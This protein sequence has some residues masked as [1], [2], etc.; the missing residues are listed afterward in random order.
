MTD[1]EVEAIDS[2]DSQIECIEKE[3]TSH[4]A[5]NTTHIHDKCIVNKEPHFVVTSHIE[6]CVGSVDETGIHT[7][8]KEGSRCPVL[9]FSWITLPVV[10]TTRGY[11][12]IILVTKMKSTSFVIRITLVID[13]TIEPV[14]EYSVVDC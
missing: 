4:R 2:V 14:T 11:T 5:V 8:H 6:R 10:N 9:W 12:T 13:A 7:T 1:I 3:S